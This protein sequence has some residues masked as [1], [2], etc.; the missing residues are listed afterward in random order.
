M[1]DA[2]A[3]EIAILVAA[4]LLMGAMIMSGIRITRG[5]HIADR[6]VALDMLSL[7]GASAGGLAAMAT[8]SMAFVDVALGVA[9]VGFLATV[10]FAGFMERGS[11]SRGGRQ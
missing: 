4:S 5:P 3:F 10:A 2:L 7:L 11:I 9:L 1:S 8:G 6:V